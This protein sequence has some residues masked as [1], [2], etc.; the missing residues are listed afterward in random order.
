MGAGVKFPLTR[1]E[2]FELG[3]PGL[4]RFPATFDEYWD[5][6]EAAEYRADFYQ[7]EI[8]AMSYETD[9][10]S[11]MVAECLHILKKIYPR[12]DRRFKVHDPNRPIY[13]ANCEADDTGI[14]NPDGS[15]VAQPPV[16]FEYRPGMN[17][18]TTPVLLFEVL[19]KN[20]RAYDLSTKLPCYK[21]IPSLRYILYID[22]ERPSVTVYER[23]EANRWTDAEYTRQSDS[24]IID[25]NKISLKELYLN[26]FF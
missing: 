8:I 21:R 24:F 22:M 25:G 20:T 5:L 15:V 3:G 16:Y 7:N 6:L 19:S 11:D 14:F 13:A 2:L 1:K 9:L 12:S 18:E 23:L 17:A 10:H 26:V 4:V